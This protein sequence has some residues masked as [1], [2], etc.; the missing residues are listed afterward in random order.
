MINLIFYLILI[1]ALIY[2]IPKFKEILK[3]YFKEEYKDGILNFYQHLSALITP[4]TYF[5]DT[6]KFKKGYLIFL[7]YTSLYICLAFIVLLLLGEL[8]IVK[9]II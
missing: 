2:L 4:Y 7:F 1:V 5:I 9:S 8:G 3:P 6:S